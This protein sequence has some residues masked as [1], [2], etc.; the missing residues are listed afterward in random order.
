MK[1]AKINVTSTVDVQSAK[2][3]ALSATLEDGQVIAVSGPVSI[4]DEAVKHPN[5]EV[6][7]MAAHDFL[8]A[9]VG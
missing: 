7:V 3:T 4:G 9:K 8:S 6:T 2:I 5:G 1:P